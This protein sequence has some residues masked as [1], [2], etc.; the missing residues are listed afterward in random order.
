MNTIAKTLTASDFSEDL[1]EIRTEIDQNTLSHRLRKALNII[2]ISQSELARMIGVKPQVIQYLCQQNIKSSR[3]TYLI[4]EALGIS[5]AWL[6]AGVEPMFF[7][8]EIENTHYRIP[9]ISFDHL[10]DYIEHRKADIPNIKYIH[11]DV[12]PNNFAT[13][14]HDNSM[15][16]RFDRGTILIIE[17]KKEYL[18]DD[19][20]IAKMA[21]HNIY[22][23]RQLHIEDNK[24]VLVPFNREMY[25]EIVLNDEDVIYGAVVQTICNYKRD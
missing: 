8:E 14:V 13:A 22:V 20:V 18:H 6:A 11:S 4:A 25:K 9:L 1:A 15:E 16:P 5:H 10:V 3:F 21:K 23:F 7:P 19:F 17:T 12:G 2:N 24:R